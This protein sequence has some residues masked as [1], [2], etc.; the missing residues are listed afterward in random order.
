MTSLQGS[1]PIYNID[2]YIERHPEICFFV[3]RNY[4]EWSRETSPEESAPAAKGTDMQD[5]PAPESESIS[6]VSKELRDAV[7]QAVAHL[8]K[9]SGKIPSHKWD[10][11]N[12]I[13]GPY[14]FFY[15]H[16]E[17]MG[18][19]ESRLSQGNRQHWTILLRYIEESFGAE[20]KEV[21][22]NAGCRSD[23]TAICAILNQGWRFTHIK[24][25]CGAFCVPRCLWSTTYK[26]NGKTISE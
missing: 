2:L 6:L 17:A 20:Y 5:I 1:L 24:D 18:Y 7:T 13:P 16:R 19:Y 3:Y 11:K 22:K 23:I 10:I 12:E 25:F 4:I 8:A 21:D 14:L 26:W 9:S 15:H